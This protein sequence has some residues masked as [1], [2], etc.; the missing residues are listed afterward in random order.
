MVEEL[1]HSF[2]TGAVKIVDLPPGRTAIGSVWAHK[3]KHDAD[4]NFTR[5]KSRLCPATPWHRL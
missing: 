2:E 5:A 1:V 3:F 4:D